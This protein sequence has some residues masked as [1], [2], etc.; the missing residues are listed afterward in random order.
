MCWKMSEKSR[1]IWLTNVYKAV[2][3]MSIKTDKRKLPVAYKGHADKREMP[4]ATDE[5]NSVC[6]MK[7]YA[8]K[9][10]SR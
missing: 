6:R 1:I 5:K 10:K 4:I 9:M 7:G 3:E 8:D 2:N